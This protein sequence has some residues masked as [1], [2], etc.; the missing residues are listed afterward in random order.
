MWAVGLSCSAAHFV[1]NTISAETVLFNRNSKE[2]Q[3][4]HMISVFLAIPIEQE[5]CPSLIVFNKRCDPRCNTVAQ[6]LLYSTKSKACDS[7]N[8]SITD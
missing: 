8:W 6:Q 1:S 4:S 2:L 3:Q 7:M 5:N